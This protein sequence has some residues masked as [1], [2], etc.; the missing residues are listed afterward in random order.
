M[1]KAVFFDR[2][3]VINDNSQHYYIYKPEQVTIVDKIPEAIKRLTKAGYLIIVVSNQGGISKGLYEHRDVAK[4]HQH[5]LSA[6]QKAGGTIHDFYYCPH[7]SSL[8]NC[9]C[10][11]PGSLMLEKAIAT[12]QIDITQSYVIGDSPRDI[13]AG[14]QLGMKSFKIESNTP[15]TALIDKILD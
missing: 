2:D 14:E 5:I 10:R 13:E 4:V 11:K 6:I 15:V 3:G 7:H 12:H 9:L 8:E 1:Q